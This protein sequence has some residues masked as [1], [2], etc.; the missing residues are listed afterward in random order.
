MHEP[1]SGSKTSPLLLLL[2][3]GGLSL[4][5]VIV[6]FMNDEIPGVTPEERDVTSTSVLEEV[7]QDLRQALVAVEPRSLLCQDTQTILE[8]LEM[9]QGRQV[10]KQDSH[11]LEH[12][13]Q[14]P[15]TERDAWSRCLAADPKSQDI[16]RRLCFHVKTSQADKSFWDTELALVELTIEWHRPPIKRPQSCQEW[17]AQPHP[18]PELVVYYSVY[19][20]MKKSKGWNFRRM[21]GGLRLPPRWQQAR[22]P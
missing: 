12:K 4:A 5:S 14:L 8:Q 15:Q 10:V 20:G 1:D 13:R 2:I 17:L 7:Q 19:G 21:T 6:T 18:E 16:R 22:A 11:W 9:G 3:L